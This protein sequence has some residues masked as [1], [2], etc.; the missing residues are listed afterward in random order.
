MVGP[1]LRSLEAHGYGYAATGVVAALPCTDDWS[2]FGQSNWDWGRWFGAFH[3]FLSGFCNWSEGLPFLLEQKVFMA[4]V[5]D[6]MLHTHIQWGP[7]DQSSMAGIPDSNKWL[8]GV[9][10]YIPISKW[11]IFLAS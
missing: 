2:W 5:G 8:M 7:L 10:T 1:Y 3:A 4:Y 6:T 9:I 11:L